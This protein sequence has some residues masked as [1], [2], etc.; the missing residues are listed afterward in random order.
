MACCQ[1]LLLLKVTLTWETYMSITITNL[2]YSYKIVLQQQSKQY[3][4]QRFWKNRV[5]SCSR[6][7]Y[8]LGTWKATGIKEKIWVGILYYW[9][10]FVGLDPAQPC[11]RTANRTE[12][13]DETDADFVDVIHTNARLLQRIGFGLPEPTGKYSLSLSFMELVLELAL[14]FFIKHLMLIISFNCA[15]YISQQVM[16]ISTQTAEWSSQ[17]VTTRQTRCGPD[18]YHFLQPVSFINMSMT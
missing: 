9:A 15:I 6:R 8:S 13:L 10:W 7:Y 4:Y 11:F 3:S 16:L 14:V 2:F 18:C 1:V 12:R 5:F 17:A